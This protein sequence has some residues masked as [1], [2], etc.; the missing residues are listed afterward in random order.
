MTDERFGERGGDY[1]ARVDGRMDGRRSQRPAGRE[2]R[3]HA[4]RV[5]ECERRVRLFLVGLAL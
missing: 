3:C 2:T 5:D 4:A 1:V